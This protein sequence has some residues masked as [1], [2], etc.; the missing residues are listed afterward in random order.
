MSRAC[1]PPLS[2]AE[3]EQIVNSVAA[4]DTEAELAMASDAIIRLVDMQERGVL[5]PDSEDAL[6]L[7][8]AEQYAEELRYVPCGDGGFAM[9][10]HAGPMT[11]RCTS[12]TW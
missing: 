7:A 5:R 10:A 6:A 3:I 12:S 1:G 4:A 11:T 8:F 2:E 9:T